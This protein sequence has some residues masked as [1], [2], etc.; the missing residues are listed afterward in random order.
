MISFFFSCDKNS[1]MKFSDEL[2]DRMIQID[3]RELKKVIS[4]YHLE[5][6]TRKGKGVIVVYLEENKEKQ[7]FVISSSYWEDFQKT[8]PSY[9]TIFEGVPII[10][11]TGLEKYVQLDSSYLHNL[12]EEIS[13]FLEKYLEDEDGTILQMPPNYNPAVWR[14]EMLGDSLVSKEVLN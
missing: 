7:T 2:K 9:Y 11:F 4:E 10:F 8:P 12:E 5:N 3:N 6:L 1:S 14:I 13:P